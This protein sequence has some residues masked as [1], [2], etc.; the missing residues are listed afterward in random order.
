MGP[1]PDPEKMKKKRQ[2]FDCLRLSS[3]LFIILLPLPTLL[4]HFLFSFSVNILGNVL[5]NGIYKLYFDGETI[6]LREE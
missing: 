5:K 4:H 2:V 1:G 6:R 3:F